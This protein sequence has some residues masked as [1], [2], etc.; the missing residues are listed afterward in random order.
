MRTTVTRRW[1]GAAVAAVALAVLAT[2]NGTA[3]AA[4]TGGP[5]PAPYARTASVKAATPPTRAMAISAAVTS[6][7]PPA[8]WS[9][10]AVDG[11]LELT[12]TS[13]QSLPLGDAR[14]EVQAGGHTLGFA[15]VTPGGRQVT[16]SLNGTTP[17]EREAA[18][19]RAVAAGLSVAAAGRRLDVVVASARS[20]APG[21]AS[22]APRATASGT[23]PAARPA[24][25]LDPGRPGPYRTVEGE[26]DLPGLAVSGLPAPVE[27][28]ATVIGPRAGQPELAGTAPLVLFL[29]GRHSTCYQGGPSG[30]S[31]GDWPC[32]TGWTP[33]PS[34]RGYLDTQRVLAS[35]GYLTVSIAANGIN[36][37]DYQ[38]LDGGAEARSQ[39]VRH[40][41]KLWADWSAHGFGRAPGVVRR[42]PR[43]DLSRVLLVG[44]SRGGE[45]VNRAAL[46][47]TEPVDGRRAPWKL[48]GLV[49]IGPTAFGDNPAPGVATVA[50]L[51]ACDGD[52]MDLQGQQYVDTGRDPGGAASAGGADH[53]LRSAVM[54]L[55]ANHNYFN[56]EWT[57][58]AAAAPAWDDWWDDTDPTC[59]AASNQR[60]APA[61]QRAVGTAYVTAAARLLVAG[62]EQALPLLDGSNVGMR[63][64]G[65]AR[66]LV[67]ALGERRR[68]A[69][70][71]GDATTVTTT[72]SGVTARVCRAA[73]SDLVPQNCLDP[74]NAFQSPHFLTPWVMGLDDRYPL[75]RA[76]ELSWTAAGGSATVRPGAG[77]SSGAP[78]AGES[79]SGASA[80]GASLAG[81]SHLELRV[82]VPP[83]D[84][85]RFGV[86]LTD[87]RGHTLT[88]ADARLTGLPGSGQAQKFWAQEV[89]L[90]LDAAAVRKAGLDLAH[91][92]GMD[93]LTRSDTGRL[94]LLD[95][96]AWQAGTTD[97]AV[98]RAT[99][100]DVAVARVPEGDA[101]HTVTLPVRVHRVPGSVDG[102]AKLWVSVSGMPGGTST[103]LDLPRGADH[104]DVPLTVGNTAWDGGDYQFAVWVK[105]ISG[106]VAGDYL[107]VVDVVE[108]DPAPT[109]SL[110]T[111]TG[112]VT[113]GGSLVYR[114]TVTGSTN[115]PVII[116]LQFLAPDAGTPELTTADL[117]PDWVQNVLGVPVDPPT[118]LSQVTEQTSNGPVIVVDPGAT[119]ADLSVPTVA[120]G[121]GEPAESLV[122]S[123]APWAGTIP[124]LD[125]G[126]RLVGTVK[127]A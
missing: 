120:D 44:H 108:D 100:V 59:G 82:V 90:P 10:Q 119:T 98:V 78:A 105:P 86:R 33:V 49:L 50:L 52:V 46:D 118:P 2:G 62:D 25:A 79:S 13:P 42:L 77:S 74:A 40:H 39:L 31:S 45:G 20:T 83:R 35:Q 75:R 41:L 122:M 124:G 84:T 113:E 36:G 26:Y 117:A 121:V 56:A 127:D 29:H 109:V 51:P 76:V 34:E 112:E 53:A 94:W 85:V 60:L 93:L 4:G 32:P 17:A 54:I 28:R 61:A 102:P 88:L 47:S 16:V 57:P 67:H 9:V 68:R 104:V 111:V 63:S 15:R 6:V 48:A 23:L 66:V 65:D 43:A 27:V 107:G 14:I 24:G 103:T 70:V 89:R 72:G 110:T 106:A 87:R 30:E 8:G 69:V 97:D 96:W 22:S 37:Q 114:A 11:G 58:G 92:S 115:I 64:A 18:L 3:Q 55:G 73:D 125:P 12:W 5:P 99:R 123:L 116:P 71:P 91:L 7:S 38:L 80:A 1:R 95:A 126:T 101:P 81:A 21:A 19:R